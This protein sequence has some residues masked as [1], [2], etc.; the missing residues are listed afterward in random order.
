M[1]ILPY[2]YTFLK[3]FCC[4]SSCQWVELKI[5]NLQA[6]F[7]AQRAVALLCWPREVGRS[8][9]GEEQHLACLPHLYPVCLTHSFSWKWTQSQ[10][11]EALCFDHD[12]RN[13]SAAKYHNDMGSPKTSDWWNQLWTAYSQT[14]PIWLKVTSNWLK[15]K[16]FFFFWFV[17]E[18]VFC[19]CPAECNI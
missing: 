15:P 7:E 18:V 2:L 14:C 4:C 11:L 1:S 3:C 6:F 5:L 10:E 8:P 12:D 17:F 19:S 16:S 13:H 9:R